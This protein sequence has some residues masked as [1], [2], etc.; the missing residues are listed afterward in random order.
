MAR[1]SD[2][3]ICQ[4]SRRVTLQA[5]SVSFLGPGT[6]IVEENAKRGDQELEEKTE[7]FAILH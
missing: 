5:E 3:R 2:R 1:K 6:V 7:A 4:V